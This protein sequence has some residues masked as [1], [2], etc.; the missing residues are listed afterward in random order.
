MPGKGS[1]AHSGQGSEEHRAAR[2]LARLALGVME[3]SCQ[4]LSAVEQGPARHTVLSDGKATV[5]GGGQL[6]V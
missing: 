4:P 5:E 3:A 2:C 1:G 6:E